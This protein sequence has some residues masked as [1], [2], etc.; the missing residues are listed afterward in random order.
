MQSHELLPTDLIQGAM[1]SRRLRGVFPSFPSVLLSQD[2]SG[3]RGGKAAGKSGKGGLPDKGEGN[4]CGEVGSR[5]RPPFINPS[6][7]SPAAVRKGPGQDGG[8]ASALCRSPPSLK[9]GRRGPAAAPSQLQPPAGTQAH[10][11]WVSQSAY[12]AKPRG[13][14]GWQAP[15]GQISKVRAHGGLG[16]TLLPGS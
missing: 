3:V 4:Q 14:K 10:P 13:G 2:R 11:A 9:G 15:R 1:V 12:G 16:S 6:H 8:A 7:N 5:G